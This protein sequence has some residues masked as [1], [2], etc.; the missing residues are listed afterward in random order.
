MSAQG[1]AEASAEQLVG[2]MVAEQAGASAVESVLLLGQKSV[3]P[4]EEAWDVES[5]EEKAWEKEIEMDVMLVEA[6]GVTLDLALVA[7]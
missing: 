4:S 2:G 3:E 6:L 5:A 1:L 7:E